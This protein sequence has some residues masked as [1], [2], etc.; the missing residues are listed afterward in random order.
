LEFQA[1]IA[2][3][4]SWR[5]TNTTSNGLV[6]FG[7]TSSNLYLEGKPRNGLNNDIE[8]WSSGIKTIGCDLHLESLYRDF[9]INT[10]R[11]DPINKVV[12]DPTGQST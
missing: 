6:K 8:N 12:I 4:N 10:L 11:Y 7:D 2:N 1:P 3:Q 9:T 5:I